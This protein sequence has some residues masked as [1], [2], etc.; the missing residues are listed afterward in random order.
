MLPVG[1][2]F[3]H[4]SVAGDRVSQPSLVL[5]YDICYSSDR[6]T[7]F[8]GVA[9]GNRGLIRGS[10]ALSQG[11]WPHCPVAAIGGWL[12]TLLCG[13]LL[14]FLIVGCCGVGSRVKSRWAC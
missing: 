6:P 8:F 10:E 3:C 1:G 5:D 11:W 7:V 13:K 9:A 4:S 14:V 2:V 12:R